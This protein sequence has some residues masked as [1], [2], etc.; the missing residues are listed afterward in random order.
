MTERVVCEVAT[1]EQESSP[2]PWS[3]RLFLEELAVPQNRSWVIIGNTG[4]VA[5]LI[6]RFLGHEAE[7]LRL[8]VT[9]Q[10]RRQGLGRSL[11][12]HAL[13]DLTHE[14]AQKIFLEVR[15]SNLIARQFYTHLGFVIE[16]LRRNYYKNPNED[17]IVMYWEKPTQGSRS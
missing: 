10:L 7:I 16:G 9:S 3:E 5:F 11:V 4:T 13:A 14:G 8:A 17:A 6:S 15:T 12:D 2:D 1:L